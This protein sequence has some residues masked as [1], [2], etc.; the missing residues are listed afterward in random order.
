M[1]LICFVFFKY[2]SPAPPFP[3]LLEMSDWPAL[4]ENILE[5]KKQTDQNFMY[6]F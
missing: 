5:V 1:V 4:S 6:G 2:M 3:C